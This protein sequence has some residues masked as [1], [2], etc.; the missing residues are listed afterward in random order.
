MSVLRHLVHLVSRFFGVVTSRR[1][2]P[3]EQDS[4]NAWLS[5]DEA[6]LFWDQQAIDQRHAYEVAVAVRKKVPDRSDITTAALLHDV[7]KR[8]SRLGAVSRSL[9]TVSSFLRLPMP[10]T[11]RRYRDHGELGARDLEAVGVDEIA[12]SFARGAGHADTAAWEAL[13]DAD[14]GLRSVGKS[15]GSGPRRNT[16]PPEVKP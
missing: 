13:V 7:G 14:N 10:D 9:A 15:S 6:A 2:S 8:H 4:V 3:A 1:L 11:W 12:V 16:I 5:A